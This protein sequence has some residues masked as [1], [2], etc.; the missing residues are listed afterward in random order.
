[1]TGATVKRLGAEAMN[2][3][4]DHLQDVCVTFLPGVLGTQSF[5]FLGYQESMVRESG[6]DH[7]K[8]SAFCVIMLQGKAVC[9]ACISCGITV[10]RR[11]ETK[12][13]NLQY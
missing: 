7:G 2:R 9:N 5:Y 4:N 1:M 10:Q 8:S 12:K 3:F 11:K 6:S 13:N